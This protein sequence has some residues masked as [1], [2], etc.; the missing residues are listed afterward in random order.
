MG[1][2]A[3][4]GRLE[5]MLEKVGEGAEKKPAAKPKARPAE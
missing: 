1:A 2:E 4:L 5:G 3:R